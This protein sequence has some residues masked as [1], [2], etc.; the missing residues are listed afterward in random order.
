MQR[1]L[2]FIYKRRLKRPKSYYRD[3]TE[4]LVNTM[5]LGSSFPCFLLRPSYFFLAFWRA[6]LASL[7]LRALADWSSD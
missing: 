6:F 2:G 1:A 3:G 4:P 7:A 5:T